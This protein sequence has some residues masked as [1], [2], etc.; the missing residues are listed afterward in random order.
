MISDVTLLLVV[1]A[2]L[3]FMRRSGDSTFGLCRF[4]WKQ[5]VIWIILG[6]AAEVP[7]LVL[8]LL[9]T[10]DPLHR[11]F[12]SPGVI[13]MTIT[14]TRMHRSLVDFASCSEV[15]HG[16]HPVSSLEFSKSKPTDTPPTAPDLVEVSTDKPVEQHPTGMSDDDLSSVIST[17]STW[18]LPTV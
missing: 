16:S 2:G 13:I 4:L 14:A 11:V 8:T 15:S 12:V 9:H 7:T 6:T 1:L 10:D 17:K 18:P 3:V 5:G